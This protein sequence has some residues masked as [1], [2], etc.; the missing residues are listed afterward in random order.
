MHVDGSKLSAAF[1]QVI[2]EQQPAIVALRVT[3]VRTFEEADLSM[4][5]SSHSHRE[6]QIDTG[7]TNPQRPTRNRSETLATFQW[8][9]HG[10]SAVGT[11]SSAN[12][13]RAH[14]AAKTVLKV[15]TS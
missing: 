15:P 10:V 2:A 14:I 5:G 4:R 3:C 13:I 12:F 6:A 7:T 9:V 11:M 8:V 1:C